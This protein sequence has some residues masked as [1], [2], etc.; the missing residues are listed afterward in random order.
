MNEDKKYERAKKRV[1]EIRGFFIHIFI[2]VIV[3]IGLFLLNIITSPSELW[4]YWPLFGWG[5]GVL[6]HGISVFG[7]GGLLGKEWE[8]RKIKQIMEKMEKE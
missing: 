2:Y 5:F 1:E 4:F 3:N 8:E 7:L 6:A